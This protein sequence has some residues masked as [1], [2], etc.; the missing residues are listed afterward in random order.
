L[1]LVALIVCAGCGQAGGPSQQDTSSV[2]AFPS[3]LT[4]YP[5]A[6]TPEGAPP[7]KITNLI[8]TDPV[9]KVMAFYEDQSKNGGWEKVSSDSM[10]NAAKV[11]IKKDNRRVLL[12]LN[13]N[14]A[15]TVV[16]ISLP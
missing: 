5:N 9:K 12:L 8:T 6:K 13:S 10:G 3:D 7:G 4:L 14:G 2:V 11:T 15:E 16:D 1:L